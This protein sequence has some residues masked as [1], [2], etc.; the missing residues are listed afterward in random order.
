[1]KTIIAILWWIS[2]VVLV[3]TKPAAAIGVV[4]GFLSC[5]GVLWRMGGGE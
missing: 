5:L 4:V 2:F 3:F 1:M